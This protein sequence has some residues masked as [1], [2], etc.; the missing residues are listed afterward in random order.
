[1]FEPIAVAP[2][3]VTSSSEEIVF[4]IPDAHGQSI[5]VQVMDV[6]GNIIKSEKNTI[7]YTRSAN[8]TKYHWDLKM[9]NGQKVTPGSYVIMV[10]VVTEEGS[11][12]YYQAFV[13]VEE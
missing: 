6:V 11:S 10:K 12:K 9:K 2:N 5:D 1:M 4:D 7:S 3:P 8:T 13:G